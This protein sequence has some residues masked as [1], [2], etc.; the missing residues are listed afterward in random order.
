MFKEIDAIFNHN[1][2]TACQPGIKSKMFNLASAQS[3]TT[4]LVREEHNRTSNQ[5]KELMG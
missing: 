4:K 5:R 2:L 1:D 3:I